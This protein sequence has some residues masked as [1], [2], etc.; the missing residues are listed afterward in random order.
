VLPTLI[1]KACCFCDLQGKKEEEESSEREEEEK[2]QR[3][4]SVELTLLLLLLPPWLLLLPCISSSRVAAEAAAA[5]GPNTV[6]DW[7]ATAI[8]LFLL[9]LPLSQSTDFFTRQISR[10]THPHLHLFIM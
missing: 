3:T 5:R 6:A 4:I 8:E 1:I 2:E 7:Q 9:L 10:P